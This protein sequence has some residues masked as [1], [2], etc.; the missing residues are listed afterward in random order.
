[1]AKE[2]LGNEPVRLLTPHLWA[3]DKL[4][5][6]RGLVLLPLW[7]RSCYNAALGIEPRAQGMHGKHLTTDTSPSLFLFSDRLSLSCPG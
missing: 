7:M 1:M 2:Q 6:D 3:L 5:E 4:Q